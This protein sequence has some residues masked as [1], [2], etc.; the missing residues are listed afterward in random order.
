VIYVVEFVFA[1]LYILLLLF[2][3]LSFFNR[4]GR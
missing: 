1:A 3:P 2:N 4:P